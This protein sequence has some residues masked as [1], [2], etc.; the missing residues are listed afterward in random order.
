MP[1]EELLAKYRSVSDTEHVLWLIDSSSGCTRRGVVGLE[2]NGEV[3]EWHQGE[4]RGCLS[5]WE[6]SP[7]AAM[8]AVGAV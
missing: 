1:L 4:L 7:V 8:F 5:A 3:R 2:T 6:R